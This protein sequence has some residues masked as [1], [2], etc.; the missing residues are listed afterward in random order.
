M[1][2]PHC[3]RRSHGLIGRGYTFMTFPS[4][5]SCEAH[6]T[7]RLVLGCALVLLAACEDAVCP[8]STQEVNGRCVQPT[9]QEA[10][11]TGL[12][13]AGAEGQLAATSGTGAA[14]A[15]TGGAK[16][17]SA[18][19]GTGAPGSAG[20]SSMSSS[21]SSG[22]GGASDPGA[23]PDPGGASDPASPSSSGSPGDPSLCPPGV[24]PDIELCDGVDNDCDSLVDEALTTLCG[25]TGGICIMGMAACVDGAWSE[26]CEGAVDPTEETCDPEGLDENCDGTVNENCPCVAGET[27]PCGTSDGIC[28][29]GT[30]TCSAEGQ[31]ST[32]CEGEVAAQS[33][34]KCD[35]EGLDENCDGQSNEGCECSEGEEETC[36]GNSMGECK[37]GNRK[38]GANGR[39]GMCQGKVAPMSRET[40]NGKDEDCDGEIDDGATCSGGMKCMAGKCTDW[41][42]P[43]ECEG[44]G[45]VCQPK[46]CNDMTGKCEAGP[47]A[48]TD[49]ACSEGSIKVGHCSSGSCVKDSEVVCSVGS[50][51]SSQWAFMENY[52]VCEPGN[53]QSSGGVTSFG[54]CETKESHTPVV[55]RLIEGTDG[56]VNDVERVHVRDKDVVCASSGGPCGKWFADPKTKDGTAQVECDIFDDGGSQRVGPRRQFVPSRDGEGHPSPHPGAS[57]CTPDQCRL[58]VGDCRV[59]Q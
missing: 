17:S 29:Q 45:N 47:A 22:T 34:E 51:K 43:E 30:Q 9:W 5:L 6:R 2:R 33:A 36:D 14:A 13:G 48:P 42:T 40:C 24:V 37:P 8:A 31:W 38:C 54:P 39:W 44:E 20:N 23:A 56:P 10:P 32:E 55:W 50:F 52:R 15:G 41:C 3:G 49:T 35:A 25:V 21:G 11:Q 19:S 58:W 27:Q 7:L 4:V 57:V 28:E 26:A 59:M 18:R 12:P 46:V 16:S 53:C 1:S